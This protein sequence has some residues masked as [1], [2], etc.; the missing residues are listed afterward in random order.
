MFMCP[1]ALL[2]AEGA[3]ANR[4]PAGGSLDNMWYKKRKAKAVIP[5]QLEGTQIYRCIMGVLNM[6]DNM[7]D[8]VAIDLA[9]RDCLNI[10]MCHP[11]KKNKIPKFW[12]RG[13]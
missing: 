12:F 5:S 10:N 1:T 13:R 6:A 8:L 4:P 7:A 3:G 11:K 9:S 2:G